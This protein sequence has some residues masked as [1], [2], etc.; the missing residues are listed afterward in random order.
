MKMIDL[1]IFVLI[2]GAVMVGVAGNMWRPWFSNDS[3]RS[4]K[5]GGGVMDRSDDFISGWF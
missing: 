4:V 2:V 5:E 3:R 1:V